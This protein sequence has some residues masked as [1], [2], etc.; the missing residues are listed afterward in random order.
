[1]SN[2]ISDDLKWNCH[3]D[4]MYISLPKQQRDF[5]LLVTKKS[6]CTGTGYVEDIQK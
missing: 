5:M 4:Y 6:Q 1:M 3:I 2:I